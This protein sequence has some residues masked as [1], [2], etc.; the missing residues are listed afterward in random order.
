MKTGRLRDPGIGS[1]STNT[2]SSG[3]EGGPRAM[4]WSPDSGPVLSQD[5]LTQL[6]LW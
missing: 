1:M 3:S 5:V 4:Q 2:N 6:G